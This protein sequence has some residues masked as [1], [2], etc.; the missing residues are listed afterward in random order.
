MGPHF[1]FLDHRLNMAA[2]RGAQATEEWGAALFQ[3][4]VS[5]ATGAPPSDPAAL[6]AVKA[7]CRIRG[8]LG[9]YVNQLWATLAVLGALLAGC[10]ALGW[11]R[12]GCC[13][14]GPGTKPVPSMR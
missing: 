6:A 9:G 5:W 2:R 12:C 8:P 3:M 10:V 1:R 13:C 4:V 11:C 14:C 7:D